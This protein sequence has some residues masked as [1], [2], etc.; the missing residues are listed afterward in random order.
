MASSSK[1]HRPRSKRDDDSDEEGVGGGAA[2][3]PDLLQFC[4]RAETLIS[5]LL[6]LSDR[7]PPEFL[8]R[9]F[10]SVLFDLRYFDSPSMFET[11]IEGNIKLEALEDQLRESCSAFM[12]RFFLLA[13]GA[14]VYHMEL[15]KYLNELQ[16]G[17]YVQCTLD[18]VLDDE[19]GRQLLAESIQLF[20]C[21]LLLVEHRMGGFLREKILVA[22][23]RYTRCFDYPNIKQICS[24]CHAHRPLSDTIL[25]VS[26]LSLRSAMILIEKP[27]VILAR[28]PFPKL[29]VDAIISRLRSDDLYD[30]ARHYPD[31]QHR[32]VALSLQARCLYILL[33]YSTEFLHDG[34]VMREIVDRFFKDHWVVP[35]FLHY[36]VDLLASWDAYKEAKLSISSCHS[37]TLIRDRCHNHCSQVRHLL[38]KIDL[39]LTGS[40]LTKDYVL[41]RFQNL[42]SLVRNCNVALRW[43]LLH[44]ISIGRKFRE[45]VTSVG[46]SEQVDEDC[47]LVLLLKTSQLEFKVKELIVELLEN[48][49]ALWNEK[50]HGASECIE[51]L[52]GHCSGSWASPCKTKN[53]SLKDWFGKLSQEVCLLDHR[54]AGS[55]G[56]I[57]YRMISTLKDIEKFHQIE[58][59]VQCKQHLSELQKYLQDMI[60]TL[61]LDNDALSTFSVITDAIYAWGYIPRFGE[62]LGKKIELDP[63]LMLILHMFFLKFRR[64]VDAPLLRVA[65]NESPDL[66]CVSNFYSSQFAAQI[67]TALD[68]LPVL[69]LEIFKE[70]GIQNQS[71]YSVNRI[72]KDKLEDLMLLDKQLKSGRAFNRASI[73]S[74]G[75][76]ILSRNFFGLINLNIK[77]W[78]VEQTIKE[79]GKRIE[80]RLNC[81]CLS[82]SVSHGILEANLRTLSTYIHSQMQMVETFQDL[83]HIHGRCILEEILTNF[84]KQSAQKVYTELLKQKQESVPFSAL[85]IN[86]SKSDTFYGNLLLQVLQLTD[87]S[88]SMFIEP[89]SGWFDAEGHELLGLLFFDVLDSCVGQEGLC[90][91]DSLLCILLKDSLEHALRSL[92]SLLDASVLNELHKM[93]DYL[94]PA[95]SLP[96]LGWTSYKNMIKNASDSWEP[97][98]PCFATIGQ[99][100]LVRCLISFKLQSTSKIKAG[101]VYSVVEGLNAS[102]YSQRD[103]ILESINSE[104]KDNPSIK[105]LQAFNKE[106]KL[107]GLFSPLQTIYISEEPPILLGRSA[108]ILSIS[109]LPQYVL[110]SHLGTLTSKTKKSI[111]D[112]SPVA[113]GLGTFLKQFHPSHMTQYVQYMGQYVRITAEIA[114]GGVYD[115][116]ILSGDPAS[117]VLKPAFWLMYF[118]RHMSISKNLAESCLPLS[119]V[120]MLQM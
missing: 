24:F 91:L 72:D 76:T 90:I 63:S 2:S 120:A 11:R 47:L 61:N 22:Y 104:M 55:S 41:D 86:L 96:L 56:R 25:D 39:V 85:L 50:K 92:K 82:S 77:D 87:P 7:V 111:I 30:Q 31:P 26:S 15:L 66:P 83:F 69:L 81:F 80:N 45:I 17:L 119:L 106:R 52:S 70:D 116:Q 93:D 73:I 100:Q 113:I 78:L 65:Q 20:G 40:V 29:V 95:T 101:R 94:G 99:L 5:E 114:Y 109:Q 38:S 117:E 23:L 49:E 32:T 110:D 4:S 58:E 107:C 6:C 8:N 1:S 19:C 44:R 112:F 3:L 75:I 36:A 51:E 37:P 28:F 57:I 98:V 62:L 108:S 88:Q 14:V 71:F 74:Q 68:T 67:C 118:C 13:N 35:I 103:E 12:H 64:W 59:N 115:P 105:F 34:F 43:L 89:M 46:I 10:E 18:R 42:L 21:L 60:K 9:H 33:L 54:R 27:E 53:E 97:L 79:L 48:K 102:I 16:E 84:L